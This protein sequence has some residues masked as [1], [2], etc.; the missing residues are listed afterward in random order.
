MH[1][2]GEIWTLG[3]LA[4]T[5]TNGQLQ[6]HCRSEDLENRFELCAH[7]GKPETFSLALLTPNKSSEVASSK[8]L[9]LGCV[10]YFCS[11]KALSGSAF[12]L[13][14]NCF[15]CSFQCSLGAR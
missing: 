12:I 8:T 14:S 1:A 10:C 11:F 13:P 6:N 4:K 7:L 3:P 5:P 2:E 15:N 9:G